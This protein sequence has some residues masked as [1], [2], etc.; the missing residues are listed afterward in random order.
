MQLHHQM[1]L[2]GE[3]I[4]AQKVIDK[5]L[6]KDNK[7]VIMLLDLFREHNEKCCKLFGNGMAPGTIER[8]ETSYKL[9][10]HRPTKKK[11][12]PLPILDYKFITNYEFWLRTERK[13]SHN[14][15]VKYLKIS[16]RS[17]A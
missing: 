15:A 8:Y 3:S 7:P 4:S 17:F 1:E 14:S 12:Y 6:G 16:G 10:L 11:M 9:L 13:C 2:D 5:Y